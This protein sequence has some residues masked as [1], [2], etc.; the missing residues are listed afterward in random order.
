[1]LE[2]I[3]ALKA[4][5]TAV[6]LFALRAAGLQTQQYVSHALELLAADFAACSLCTV[7]EA[8]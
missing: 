6:A 1:M 7:F 4:S 2:P 5:I 3:Q 8:L